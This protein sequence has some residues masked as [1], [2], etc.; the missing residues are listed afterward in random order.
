MLFPLELSEATVGSG[1]RR[2][3]RPVRP[4]QSRRGSQH[5]S[6]G[7]GSFELIQFGQVQSEAWGLGPPKIQSEPAQRVD[8]LGR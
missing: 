4:A 8:S 5:W 6:I 1:A 2:V 7:R 3:E